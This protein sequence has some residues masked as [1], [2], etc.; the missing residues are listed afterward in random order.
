MSLAADMRE[1]GDGREL[2]LAKVVASLIGVPSDEVYR[3]AERERRRWTRIRNGVIAA[4]AVL[5]VF[6]TA[7]RALRPPPA[8]D[9]TKPFSTPR[10]KASQSR[11]LGGPRWQKLLRAGRAFRSAFWSRRRAC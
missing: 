4:L 8:Q 10:W 9:A 3:R 1:E 7:T 5:A 11:E 2:A 6:S